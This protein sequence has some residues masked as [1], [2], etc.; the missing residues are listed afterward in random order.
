ML[1]LLNNLPEGIPSITESPKIQMRQYD[2]SPVIQAILDYLGENFSTA[3][4]NSIYNQCWNIQTCYGL[5][6][7]IWGRKVGV[8]RNMRIPAQEEW[9]GFDNANDDWFPFNDGIF[10]TSGLTESYSL[11][12]EAFRLLI[13][14]KAAANITNCTAQAINNWLSISFPNRGNCYC[15]DLGNMVV[16]YVFEFSLEIFEIT[17]LTNGKVLPRPAGVRA[18]L[19]VNGVTYNVN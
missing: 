15:E 13:L 12:D 6:L 17:V 14:S 4:I 16:R 9:F 2:A 11:S 10:Y 5:W 8:D 7:D 1:P 18:T 19:V 3:V